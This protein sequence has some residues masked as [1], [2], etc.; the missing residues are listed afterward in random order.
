L[1]NAV[2]ALQDA[3]SG[4]GGTA[5][6]LTSL[7]SQINDLVAGIDVVAPTVTSIT[8]SSV[9][10]DS[11]G[12][13]NAGDVVTATVTFSEAVLATGAPT[14]DLDIGGEVDAVYVG[15]AGTDKLTFEYTILANQTDTDGISVP[16][17]PL[18]TGVGNTIKDSWGNDAVTTFAAIGDNSAFIVDNGPLALTYTAGA[19]FGVNQVLDKIVIGFFEEF[20]SVFLSD[21]SASNTYVV[22]AG[23]HF[24]SVDDDITSYISSSLAPYIEGPATVTIDFSD[25]LVWNSETDVFYLLTETSLRDLYIES[26]GFDSSGLTIDEYIEIYTIPASTIGL[27]DGF[28]AG[29]T[30]GSDVVAQLDGHDPATV[31]LTVTTPLT[32]AQAVALEE[33]GFDLA[34]VTFSIRDYDTTVQGALLLTSTA[35]VLRSAELVTAIGDELD[36]EAMRFTSFDQR[37]NLRI[38]AL[39]GDDE[40]DAGRGDDQIVG[41][42]GSD[43]IELTY[44]DFSNDTV[45]YQTIYDGE[46]VPVT[47]LTFSSDAGLYLEGSQ[48]SATINGQTVVYEVT[49][50]TETPEAAVANFANLASLTLSEI[51]PAK[52]VVGVNIDMEN[53][54]FGN[55]QFSE[56]DITFSENDITEV[57]LAD[58][59]NGQY[60]VPQTGEV[61]IP[62]GNFVGENILGAA[63]LNFVVQ[64][65]SPE[66]F[67]MIAY[68]GVE[69]GQTFSI[70]NEK[71]F[72]DPIL[73]SYSGT[74][75]YMLVS[76]EQ[77]SIAIDNPTSYADFVAAYQVLPSS[78][79]LSG[80]TTLGETV[81]FYGADTTTVLEVTPGTDSLEAIS[82]PGQ[83]SRWK[84][85]FS[86]HAGDYPNNASLGGTFEFDR[87]V[88][89][90]IDS[91][92]VT[93]DIVYTAPDQADPAATIAALKTAIEAEMGAGRGLETVLGSVVVESNGVADV[94]LVLEGKVS[95]ANDTVQVPTF[96]VDSAAIDVAG[97]QQQTTLSYSDDNAD[98]YTGGTL[99]ATIA[100]QTITADMVAGNALASVGALV[101]KIEAENLVELEIVEQLR[102]TTFNSIGYDQPEGP[103]WVGQTWLGN[104][105]ENRYRDIDALQQ[106]GTIYTVNAY[107]WSGQT[108]SITQDDFTEA[109]VTLIEESNFYNELIKFASWDD[110]AAVWQAAFRRVMTDENDSLTVNV[111]Q[112]DDITRIIISDTD[113]TNSPQRGDF[114]FFTSGTALPGFT[115]TA[116]TETHDPI[117]AD[118]E[119]SYEGEYQ[120]ATVLLDDGGVSGGYSARVDGTDVYAGDDLSPVYF[121]N[122]RIYL[123]ITETDPELI[124][125]LGDTTLD[126]V[127]VSADMEPNGMSSTALVAAIN[128]RITE[129]NPDSLDTTVIVTIEGSFTGLEVLNYGDGQINEYW[130]VQLDGQWIN[131]ASIFHEVYMSSSSY[132]VSSSDGYGKLSYYTNYYIYL[133]DSNQNYASFSDPLNL[134]NLLTFLT[135]YAEIDTADFNDDGD[136]V[137]TSVSGVKELSVKL[138]FQGSQD[139]KTALTDEDQAVV[140]GVIEKVGISGPAPDLGNVLEKAELGDDGTITLTAKDAGREMFEI[141]DVRLDYAGVKQI[142]TVTLE[143][144][145]AYDQYSFD[146]GNGSAVSMRADAEANVYYDGGKV[147]ANIDVLDSEGAVERT[148]TV[149]ADMAPERSLDQIVLTL[150]AVDATALTDDMVFD[151]GTNAARVI[152]NPESIDQEEINIVESENLGSFIANLD[153]VPFVTRAELSNGA[154]EITIDTTQL[155]DSKYVLF[156]NFFADVSFGGKMLQVD[157]T[158]TV[159]NASVGPTSSSI[160]TTVNA[161]VETTSALADAIQVK[162]AGDLAGVLGSVTADGTTITLKAA[163]AGELTFKVSDITLDYAGVKQIAEVDFSQLDD[164][165]SSPISYFDGGNLAVTIKATDADGNQ[166]GENIVISATM[167]DGASDGDADPDAEGSLAALVAEIESEIDGAVIQGETAKVQL[168]EVFDGSEVLADNSSGPRS[169]TLSFF[170]DTDDDLSTYSGQSTF[171]VTV[172]EK[173]SEYFTL[174]GYRGY[175]FFFTSDYGSSSGVTGVAGYTAKSLVNWLNSQKPINDSGLTISMVDGK[176]TVESIGIG[177]DVTV[178]VKVVVDDNDAILDVNES[179]SGHS[180]QYF[181]D[182]GVDGDL[183]AGRLSGIVSSVSA[184]QNGVIT[185]TSADNVK[186]QF[187]VTAAT[188]S[189][190]AKPEITEISYSSLDADYFV[191]GIDPSASAGRVSLTVDGLTYIV[192]MEDTMVATMAKLAN[193]VTNGQDKNGTGNIEL[194]PDGTTVAALTTAI[195]VRSGE[196]FTFTAVADD[197]PLE[198]E[199]SASVDA[200]RQVT[201]ISFGPDFD[202]NDVDDVDFIAGIGREISITIAGQTFTIDGTS[203]A[204][205]MEDLRAQLTDAVAADPTAVGIAAKLQDSGIVLG[206]EHKLTLTARYGEADPLSVSDLTRAGFD[207]ADPL[208]VGQ[209]VKLGFTKQYLTSVAGTT[210]TLSIELGQTSVQYELSGSETGAEIVVAIAAALEADP[211][212]STAGLT[213]TDS[214][215]IDVTASYP[216]PN[217]LGT[218]ASG[219][220]NTVRLFEENGTKIEITTGFFVEE[221]VAGNI[222]LDP[223]NPQTVG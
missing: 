69:G 19:L 68:Y 101:A 175:S 95:P 107:S 151:Y 187:V 80:V 28:L 159:L 89:V 42:L 23:R 128:Q 112:A 65:N 9:G 64:A 91:V 145:A 215:F 193:A 54:F 134:N 178:G 190:A 8:L 120:Q 13:L 11:A 15:G 103:S 74:D 219:A 172:D 20:G 152:L 200:T 148:V 133:T 195:F 222:V 75:Q 35:D 78:Q 48:L 171:T 205:L 1:S 150:S 33:A 60:T 173:S 61:F 182:T 163:T 30:L 129:G 197:D 115:L 99:S 147:Y 131:G 203:R 24:R 62:Y 36:N 157:N 58:F 209:L 154:V 198:I 192:T 218:V 160:L 100:G 18:Q 211:L 212:V 59:E 143:D 191:T 3:S 174:S 71:L 106:D 6:T 17:D 166:T 144:M 202:D 102:D 196:T 141:S 167:A 31:D 210:K 84:V 96:T 77:L 88:S 136:I 44:K 137:I 104:G 39:E 50:P 125:G 110:F 138:D 146:D 85:E 165:E 124:G 111:V 180:G 213:E 14:L 126:T 184:D 72:M 21:L 49:S 37:V 162:I 26:D 135:N 93:A 94:V 12:V 186:Q 127:T 155:V 27:Y 185:L 208:N 29:E 47:T 188:A 220:A 92:T 90:T 45:I 116:A 67:L 168:P 16:E 10:A 7:Q 83:K 158:E 216:G 117:L 161:A 201:E 204:E 41:G 153:A 73:S 223:S 2:A 56:N 113:L 81:T 169:F 98:Y 130:P 181:T 119:Q 217:V 207:P 194:H 66:V 22:P 164:G 43:V 206:E 176:I 52:I 25:K 142:A 156:N 149:S 82:N 199:G 140:G 51:D 177:A 123:S 132:S 34:E 183:G 105:E 4:A 57:T 214:W 121:D 179:D 79:I 122:G 38:E 5:E 32:I 109:S 46:T 189:D 63:A 118:A 40:I 53:G 221:T 97:E 86:D 76:E 55:D 114:S 70:T 87:Q 170:V 108:V 139:F